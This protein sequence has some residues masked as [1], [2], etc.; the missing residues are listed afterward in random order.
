V[1]ELST[2]ARPAADPPVR[3]LAFAAAHL[4]SFVPDT[5]ARPV[6]PSSLGPPTARL[7]LLSKSTLL[8]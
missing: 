7:R 4:A 6:A 2:A 8:I 3:V 5:R 1:A